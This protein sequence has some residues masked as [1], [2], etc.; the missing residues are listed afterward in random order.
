M[1]VPPLKLPLS[2]PP[3]M[4]SW[5][6][7][8]IEFDGSRQL[9]KRCGVPLEL[10]ARPRELFLLLLSHVGEVVSKEEILQTVWPGRIVTDASVTKCV[11]QLRQVL[12]DFDHALIVTAHGFGYRLVADVE[13]QPSLALAADNSSSLSPASPLD[14]VPA[15]PA[16][17]PA[18]SEL[19][20]RAR[21]RLWVV[22]LCSVLALVGAS[23]WLRTQPSR[24]IAASG[25][26][27]VTS[28]DDDPL[29]REEYRTAQFEL[30]TRSAASIA[31]ASAAF[32]HLTERYPERAAGWSGLADTFLLAREFGTTSEADAYA[33]AAHAARTA[34]GLDP[35]SA[36][37]WLEMAF[38]NFWSDGDVE[39]GLKAFHT[40]LQLNPASARG[41]LWYGNALAAS[42]RFD[43]ALRALAHARALDPDSRAI[44][45][46]ESWTL[47]LAGRRDAGLATM[48]RLVRIDPGFLSWHTYLERCYLV[49]GRD[50]DF[51][52]EALETAELRGKA[53]A[54]AHLAVV[55]EKYET[56]GRAAMLDQLTRDAVDAWKNGRGSAVIIAGYRAQA[57]D[58]TGMVQWLSVAATQHDIYLVGMTAA[59]EFNDYWNDPAVGQLAAL[60]N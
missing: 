35:K 21:R 4:R 25:G 30:A 11:A 28:Y 59:P 16:P 39:A 41:W 2:A 22:A 56:G 38:V 31:A 3:S 8:G 44:I 18:L 58:R 53:D 27:A 51:L 33:A 15:P 42:R 23:L 32:R 20:P 34:I 36:D 6:A 57:K 46:D 10:E 17:A 55:A 26:A 60:K 12:G 5:L 47:F 54:A 40:G 52:H 48:E 19:S 14:P 24:G 13:T 50:Q 45:A 37:A 7:K 29:A 49:L 9:L 43:D 1:S